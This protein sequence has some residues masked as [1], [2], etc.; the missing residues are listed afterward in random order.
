MDAK[1]MGS[2]AA[3]L[4]II[5]VGGWFA[6]SKGMLGGKTAD[7]TGA[8]AVQADGTKGGKSRAKGAAGGAG[9]AGGDGAR[10]G[11]DEPEPGPVAAKDPEPDSYEHKFRTAVAELYM[12]KNDLENYKQASRWPESARPAEEMAPGGGLLP[13]YTSPTRIPLVKRRADGTPDPDTMGKAQILLQQDRFQLVGDDAVTVSVKALGDKNRE[14]PIRCSDAR[15]MTAGG[16]QAA[17]A[18]PPFSFGCKQAKDG[19]VVAVFVPKQSP[20]RAQ[21]GSIDLDFDLAVDREDGVQERGNARVIVHYVPQSP[22]R[23]TGVVREA[24]E[25]GSLAYYLGF[26]AA[27]PGFY[28]LN[29]RVDSGTDDKIFANINVRQQVEKAGPVE[30]RAELFGKLIVDSQAKT[31]R[32]RDIDGEYVPEAGEISSIPGKDGI[33]YGPK[34]VD[35]SKVKG[36]DWQAP[37]KDEHMK[38]YQDML[39]KAQENCDKNFEG[40]KKP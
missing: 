6:R 7:D 25:G 9:G 1:R 26:E 34:P 11:T 15:A 24:Y 40:C 4:G 10:E 20:F 38:N 13:H 2:I 27:A 36:D 30:L 37:E 17:G 8:D 35:Q 33:F 31:V 5:L 12:A 16:P 18:I 39:G 3:V 28:R 14:L 19:S 29:V 23:L 21:A 32:L 22:G